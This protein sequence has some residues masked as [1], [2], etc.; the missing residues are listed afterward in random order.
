MNYLTEREKEIMAG[1]EYTFEDWENLNEAVDEGLYLREEIA[2]M[3]KEEL[4]RLFESLR[5]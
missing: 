1:E 5:R 3:D 4:D 2:E